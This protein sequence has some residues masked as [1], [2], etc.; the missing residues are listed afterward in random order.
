MTT[1]T[2]LGVTTSAPKNYPR[3][4]NKREKKLLEALQQDTNIDEDFNVPLV[5]SAIDQ[6]NHLLASSTLEAGDEIAAKTDKHTFLFHVQSVNGTVVN[7]FPYVS[8][9]GL[10]LNTDDNATDGVLGWEMTN[11][12]LGNSKAAY[13]VG[14]LP[15]GK[16]V[17]LE[18]VIGIDDISDVTELALGF[19]KAEAFQAAVDN[20]DEMA[21]FNIGQD[22]DGQI[23]IHTI[24]NNASTAEVDTTETDWADSKY[25]KLRIEVTNEG[26][27]S[28]KLTSAQTSAVLA[29]A[30]TLATP[31]VTASFSFDSAEVIVP[32]LYLIAETGDPGVSV[33]S[34]K[35][36][37][38]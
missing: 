26:A 38:V 28:F 9:D 23:E 3:K 27:C 2:P 6:E 12:I 15:D 11:G 37:T 19:R 25:Y 5:W 7:T 29:D 32:F 35:V 1:R 33:Y 18:A 24:L 16:P 10:E 22:A 36:G 13:T 20:Y 34:W 31:T 8:A 21:S 17:F 30:A 4:F 14:S